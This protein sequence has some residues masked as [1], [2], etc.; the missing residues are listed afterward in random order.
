[1]WIAGSGIK[2]GQVVGATDALGLRAVESPYHFRDITR[3]FSTNWAW[4]S[5]NYFRIF[6][7]DEAN[8]HR[9]Q[10][11]KEIIDAGPGPVGGEWSRGYPEMIGALDRSKPKGIRGSD[12]LSAFDAASGNHIENPR[13]W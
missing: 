2:G 8:L 5:I 1:M 10:P 6:G 3:P 9:G 13:L 4:T 7:R 12:H 11:H